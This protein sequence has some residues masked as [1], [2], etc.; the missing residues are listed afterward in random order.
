MYQV[1]DNQ[2]NKHQLYRT[3]KD[4]ITYDGVRISDA[5]NV[6]ANDLKAMYVFPVTNPG[7]PD[8]TW[9]TVIGGQDVKLEGV[10]NKPLEVTA[11]VE[12]QTVPKELENRRKEIQKSVVAFASQ[13]RELIAGKPDYLKV[14]SWSDK[15]RRAERFKDG[16]TP[17]TEDIAI[18]TAEADK[19]GFGE[20]PEQLAAIQNEKAAKL[21]I[22]VST[23]DGMESAALKAI[24]DADMDGLKALVPALETQ[25][26]EA[27][28]S[29][30]FGPEE[31]EE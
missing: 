1:T 24:D 17:S 19:R 16:G 5:A 4:V 20:T 12:Y 13:T 18:L 10:A 9:Q 6:P 25:A 23:I 8:Q 14:S 21:A 7:E 28:V 3:S 29:L 26:Q 31:V 2:L 27:L 22:A 15:A 30:G 11:T